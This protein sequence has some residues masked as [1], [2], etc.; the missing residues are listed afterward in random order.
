MIII[1]K[2]NNVSVKLVSEVHVE[3]VFSASSGNALVEKYI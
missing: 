1:D 2:K 3:L